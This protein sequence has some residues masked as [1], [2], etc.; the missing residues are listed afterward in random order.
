MIKF[1]YR[2]FYYVSHEVISGKEQK[3]DP[4][5]AIDAAKLCE[6]LSGRHVPVVEIDDRVLRISKTPYQKT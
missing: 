6:K 1:L 5:L 3:S 2:L 4:S